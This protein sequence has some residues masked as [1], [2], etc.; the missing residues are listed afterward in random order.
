MVDLGGFEF[1]ELTKRMYQSVY[2]YLGAHNMRVSAWEAHT[3]CTNACDTV[4]IPTYAK[5]CVLGRGAPAM[6]VD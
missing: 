1:I 5:E 6:D 3:V 2:L 4:H